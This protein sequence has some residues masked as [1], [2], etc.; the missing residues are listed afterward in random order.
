VDTVLGCAPH[1]NLQPE[2]MSIVYMEED[3]GLLAVFWFEL[4]SF[5]WRWKRGLGPPGLELWCD[6][7]G[8]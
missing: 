8:D 1:G 2:V 7:L 6:S 5:V 3:E 4:W